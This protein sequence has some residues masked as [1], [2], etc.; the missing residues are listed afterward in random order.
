MAPLN[1]N[2]IVGGQDAEPGEWPWQVSVHYNPFRS[3]ICGGTLIHKQWVMTAAHCILNPSANRW[4]LYMG[5]L[6]QVGPNVNEVSRTLSQDVIVHPDYNA[7]A[8]TNDIALMKLSSPVN[9]TDFIRPICLAGNGSEFT[10]SISCWSTGWGRIRANVSLTGLQTLQE[11]EI[12]VVENDRCSR[13]YAGIRNINIIASMVCAGVEGKGACQG[14]SGGP[15]QCVQNN[16]W[17]Q[18][19]ITSFGVPCALGIPEV[20][21]RVSSFENWI[22][23]QV[24]Q[25][26]VTFVTFSKAVGTVDTA[27][28]SLLSFAIILTTIFL[29]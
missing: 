1:S 7:T 22:R 28:A 3:H 10:N 27:Y 9:F 13:D 26:N 5:R 4:T 6:N 23:S 14:D 20:Y 19:G 16:Q 15:L 29:Q 17:I 18:A 12:P 24:S 11:V 8:I 2:R 25:A 21:S